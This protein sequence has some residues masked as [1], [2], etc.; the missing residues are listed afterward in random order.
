MCL[1]VLSGTA[2]QLRLDATIT[3]PTAEVTL[4][5]NARFPTLLIP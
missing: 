4:L 1:F 2:I 5:V 3:V